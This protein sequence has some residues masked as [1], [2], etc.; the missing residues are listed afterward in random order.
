[1]HFT[2]PPEP[3][4][5]PDCEHWGGWLNRVNGLCAKPGAAPVVGQPEHG[6]A[7]WVRATGADDEPEAQPSPRE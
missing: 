6:C 3:H 7:Y 2:A 4:R 1:M 5:C